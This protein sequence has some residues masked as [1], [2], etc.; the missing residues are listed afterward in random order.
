METRQR[1]ILAVLL[2]LLALAATGLVLTSGVVNPALR[3]SPGQQS[4]ARHWSPV[5]QGP[6]LTAQNLAAL[7]ETHREQY[8][9]SEALRLADQD[10]DLAFAIALRNAAANPTPLTLEGRQLQARVKELESQTK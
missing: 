10:I 3:Q 6:M 9:A 4:V 1:T 8:F 7:A 5:D 2:L